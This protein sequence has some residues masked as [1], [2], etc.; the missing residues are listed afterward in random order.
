MF[1]PPYTV[2]VDV[3]V[4]VDETDVVVVVAKLAV[5]SPT[6]PP[7]TCSRYFDNRTYSGKYT[8]FASCCRTPPEVPFF[9]KD[10]DS[11]PPRETLLMSFAGDDSVT[12]GIWLSPRCTTVYAICAWAS[13]TSPGIELKHD[14]GQHSA[15]PRYVLV[16]FHGR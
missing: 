5:T 14:L 9:P 15:W 12:S 13:L 8:E 11:I 6:E 10:T 7:R 16:P 4:H 1:K 2:I 3:V